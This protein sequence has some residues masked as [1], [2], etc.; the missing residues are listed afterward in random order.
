MS[1][2]AP[3]PNLFPDFHKSKHLSVGYLLYKVKFFHSC[4]KLLVAY[5]PEHQPELQ[6]QDPLSDTYQQNEPEL[7]QCHYKN[8]LSVRVN[9]HLRHGSIEKRWLINLF[10][11]SNSVSISR[12]S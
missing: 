6:L 1:S 7:L 3:V 4:Q 8:L 5:L 10:Q 2:H 12:L 11:N 9:H